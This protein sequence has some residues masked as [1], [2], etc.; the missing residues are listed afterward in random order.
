MQAQPTEPTVVLNPAFKAGEPSDAKEPSQGD[1]GPTLSS[2]Q[3]EQERRIRKA[4]LMEREGQKLNRFVTHGVFDDHSGVTGIDVTRPEGHEFRRAEGERV[5]SRH[6]K[7]VSEHH[8]ILKKYHLGSSEAQS[9]HDLVIL[10]KRKTGK[11]EKFDRFVWRTSPEKLKEAT[12]WGVVHNAAGTAK[13]IAALGHYR[14]KRAERALETGA[15]SDKDDAKMLLVDLG[16]D[17]IEALQELER[18]IN[19]SS[20]TEVKLKQALENYKLKLQELSRKYENDPRLADLVKYDPQCLSKIKAS[21]NASVAAA[22]TLENELAGELSR[23]QYMDKDS[24]VR[25]FCSAVQANTEEEGLAPFISTQI[26]LNLNS[27]EEL[28]KNMKYSGRA[29]G[30][31]LS[32]HGGLLGNYIVDAQNARKVAFT[33]GLDLKNPVEKAHQGDFSDCPSESGLYV[34]DSSEHARTPEER[35]HALWAIQHIEGLTVIEKSSSTPQAPGGA[36]SSLS[37]P[38][39][40]PRSDARDWEVLTPTQLQLKVTNQPDR[41]FAD[42]E[43]QATAFRKNRRIADWAAHDVLGQCDTHKRTIAEKTAENAKAFKASV[44]NEVL[45]GGLGRGLGEIVV[46]AL[47]RPVLKMREDYTRFTTAEP[48]KND[49]TKIIGDMDTAED[50]VRKEELSTN[51]PSLAASLREIEQLGASALAS[52]S[53]ELTPYDPHDILSLAGGGVAKFGRFFMTEIYQKHP[54]LGLLFTASYGVGGVAVLSGYTAAHLPAGYLAVAKAVGTALAKSQGAQVIAV[55]FTQ[56]KLTIAM[57]EALMHGPRSWLVKGINNITEDPV[58]Y[59]VVG[60]AAIGAGWM[61]MYGGVN[62]PWLSEHLRDDA[63]PIWEMG[64]AAASAKLLVIGIHLF[65]MPKDR[66]QFK[67]AEIELRKMAIERLEAKA[68]ADPKHAFNPKDEVAIQIEVSKLKLNILASLCIGDDQPDDNP[69]SENRAQEIKAELAH[70]LGLKGDHLDES[71]AHEFLDSFKAAILK[72]RAAFEGNKAQSEE[73]GATA[74]LA[75]PL[76]PAES[77][78]TKETPGP[79]PQDVKCSEDGRKTNPDWRTI[80][81]EAILLQLSQRT[82]RLKTLPDDEKLKISRYLEA[83]LAKAEDSKQVKNNLRTPVR[84]QLQKELQ[85]LREQV[86]TLKDALY[87][88]KHLSPVAKSLSL[89]GKWIGSTLRCVGNIIVQPCA[90]GIAKLRGREFHWNT[91]PFRQWGRLTRDGLIRLWHAPSKVVGA[92]GDV[93]DTAEKVLVDAPTNTTAMVGKVTNW[94]V[95]AN[96]EVHDSTAAAREAHDSYAKTTIGGSARLQQPVLA[97]RSHDSLVHASPVVTTRQLARRLATQQENAAVY[98][99]VGTFLDSCTPSVGALESKAATP[100]GAAASS[101]R[102]PWELKKVRESRLQPGA[103]QPKE[104]AVF[105]QQ[106]AKAEE[107]GAGPQ[108]QSASSQ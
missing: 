11:T 85:G 21:L 27:I 78:A 57:A 65:S 56:A 43:P 77:T 71:R 64:A 50:E 86:K 104:A 89:V 66:F 93:F 106:A 41:L 24:R 7:Y 91:E 58:K 31:N 83:Y 16:Q 97:M 84:D 32:W 6:K 82:S 12:R 96:E 68:K 33:S 53:Y 98:Q 102:E 87:P 23:H 48:G 70:L 60:A 52:P 25:E 36:A 81:A 15:I 72:Q 34:F 18:L 90:A 38:T 99:T 61:L 13:V 55:G 46:E 54:F 4:R 100:D 1:A 44:W 22:Q 107:K 67:E 63:G 28:N 74:G 39:L 5:G 69:I 88:P 10:N 17:R 92:V 105:L 59:A 73:A 14:V 20:V 35:L 19:D 3:K 45:V 76:V 62:V 51:T 47:G 94:N 75:T 95:A 37:K 42:K 30:E 80:E 2:K 79:H 26:A 108:S 40:P 103:Y 8:R 101:V 9:G 49:I 29:V